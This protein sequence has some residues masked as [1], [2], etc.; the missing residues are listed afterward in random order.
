MIKLQF[1]FKAFLGSVLV[2]SSTLSAAPGSFS[3]SQPLLEGKAGYFFFSNCTMRKIYNNGGLDVQLCASYPFWHPTDKWAL[4]AYGSVEYFHRSGNSI[5]GDQKTS[6]WAVPVNLGLK[7]VYAINEKVLYYF[8]AGPRYFHVHQHNNSSYVSKNKSKNGLG[9][10][11]NTGFNYILSDHFLIDIFGE[12]S[13]GKL[14]FH[15]GKSDVYTS[16]TQI[17]GFTFGGGFG[18]KF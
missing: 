8:A 11:A 1:K 5:N 2:V 13:Y 10:F 4:N 3:L 15:S 7:P 6:L 12:Y 18:Y 17:G 16:N 9:F 14:H